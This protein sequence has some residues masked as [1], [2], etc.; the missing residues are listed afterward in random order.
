MMVESSEAR[1]DALIRDS[2]EIYSRGLAEMVHADGREVAATCVLYSGGNDSTTL[3]HLFRNIADYAVHANTTIGVERTRQFVRETCE[4]WGLPLIEETPPVSYR[5]LVIDQ[6]FPGP[7]M[8]FKMYQRL[9]ERCLRPARKKLVANPRKERVVFLA[10]RR[11]SESAR[12]AS[13]PEF[14]REG[15]VVWISP[16]VN[17][18]SDDMALYR[19]RNGLPVNPISAA[20]GMSGECLCGAFAQPGEYERVAECDHDVAQQ[21][22]DLEAEVR[23]A[24]ESDPKKF[25]EHACQWGWGAY[26]ND[27]AA[28][29]PKSGPMCSSC[30]ARFQTPEAAVGWVSSVSPD[31]TKLDEIR[32]K[33]RKRRAEQAA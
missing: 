13:V 14:E 3:A 29:N 9:K 16:L 32:E 18:T 8:H 33:L 26:K 7:A 25:K 31:T 5:D 24:W 19:K 1:I 11:R 28:Q 21:I 4:G 2:W 17:W 30:D 12:R 27:P 10:G 6:G 15:S 22:V 23:S 20:L